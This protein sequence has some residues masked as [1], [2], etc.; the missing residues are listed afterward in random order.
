MIIVYLHYSRLP[1]N[2]QLNCAALYGHT[3]EVVRLL[4]RGANPNWRNECGATAVHWACDN[5]DHQTLAVLVNSKHANLNIMDED[6][7]TPLHYAC[8]GG[9]FECVR[10]LLGADCDSG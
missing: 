3:G 9:S 7:D 4:G 2:K 1:L 8:R 5:D 6:K 10:V